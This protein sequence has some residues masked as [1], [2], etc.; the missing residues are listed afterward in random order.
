MG[1]DLHALA[2]V[3][4]PNPLAAA[5][6]ALQLSRSGAF[7]LIIDRPTPRTMAEL[8]PEIA[9][10]EAHSVYFGGPV[11]PNRLL[12][13]LRSN[14]APQ[15]MRRVIQGVHLGSYELILKRII[16]KG[17]EEFRTYAGYGF[18]QSKRSS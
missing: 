17:E 11:F 13:L 8:W 16:A 4:A 2:I 6:S 1:V 5:R 18:S 10:L 9:G 14:E 7:G 15:G 3:R 12:F